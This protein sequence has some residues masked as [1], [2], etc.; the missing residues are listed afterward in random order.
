VHPPPA[1]PAP[2]PAERLLTPQFVLIVTIGLAYFLALGALLPTVPLLVTNVLGGDEIAVGIAVG[3]FAL[4]AVVVRPWAGRIGDRFGRRALILVG[5]TLVGLSIAA[6]HLAGTSL[7]AMIAVRLVGGIGEA[8]MF[9]GAGTM[10]TDLSPDHRRGEALSYWSVAIYG[11]MAFGPALGEAVLGPEQHFGRVW[12]VCAALTLGGAVLALLV[13]ETLVVDGTAPGATRSPLLHRAALLPGLVLFLVMV[14][15]A[16]F[17][18]LVPLYVPQVDLSGSR[19]VFLI[20]GVTVL[21]VRIFGARIPDRVGARRAATAATVVSAVGLALIA[22]VPNAVG[23]VA[24]AVVFALGMSLLFPAV[25]S[26]SLAGVPPTERGSVVGTIST[27]F[28]AA[29]GIGAALLGGLAA[30]FDYRGAFAGGAVS[31]L[32][33]FVLL[34]T[35]VR[36][37]PS[38]EEVDQRSSSVSSP[39]VTPGLSRTAFTASSTPGMNDERS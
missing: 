39:T 33:G 29:Q 1:P 11:G 36:A 5:P 13:R 27:F 31:C 2:S 28:D 23:L 8:A 37:E 7:P 4:G 20:Y 32:V 26:L 34:R 3:A 25:S 9:V 6:Y 21:A 15:L 35:L 10:I 18:E 16:G 19:G 22:A 14:G 30:L 38:E 12:T 24:G 17:L